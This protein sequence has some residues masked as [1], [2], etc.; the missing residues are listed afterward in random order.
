MFKRRG[1]FNL[2]TYRHHTI[3]SGDPV[4]LSLDANKSEYD[5]A[6]VFHRER[7]KHTILQNT[8]N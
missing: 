7:R 6:W 2:P 1:R 8:T 4:Y 5:G 3:Y